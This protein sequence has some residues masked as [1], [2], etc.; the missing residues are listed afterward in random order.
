M[1]RRGAVGDGWL[2][3][4]FSSI[5]LLLALLLDESLLEPAL[6]DARA[7]AAAAARRARL[8]SAERARVRKLGIRELWRPGRAAVV[9]VGGLQLWCDIA[10]VLSE[11]HVLPHL[12][13]HAT[14]LQMQ[15]DAPVGG[16]SG[17]SQLGSIFN[18]SIAANG[19][20]A[21]KG[22][23]GGGWGGFAPDVFV[24][25]QYGDR[26]ATT[27]I[28]EQIHATR[29]S[30]SVF[31]ATEP[32]RSEIE[33]ADMMVGAV[34]VSIGSRREYEQ[35]GDELGG[36]LSV[37]VCMPFL[38]LFAVDRDAYTPAPSLYDNSPAAASG[39]S[40]AV[41]M[42]A[43]A[44][45]TPPPLLCPL[46]RELFMPTDPEAWRARSNYTAFIAFGLPYPRWNVINAMNGLFP[47]LR[48]DAP[49]AGARTMPW[50][51]AF[52]NNASGK[53]AFLKSYRYSICP[54]NSLASGYVTEKLVQAHLAGAVPIYWGAGAQPDVGFPEIF[55]PKRII[56]WEGTSK[57][58]AASNGNATLALRE[59]IMQL[60]LNASARAAFFAEPILAPTAQAWVEKSCSRAMRL[61][62]R[63]FRILLRQ[64]AVQA[65]E[66]ALDEAASRAL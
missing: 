25:G 26:G 20:I 66:A 3:R 48:V 36:G 41:S 2:L 43:N 32:P 29:A 59:R 57:E 17:G 16:I 18:R 13:S 31:F 47:G 46:R 21:A 62:Q 60:E 34:N 58:D 23:W 55:N 52:S 40:S 61:L 53:V 7:A 28:L 63:A 45:A 65:Y 4:V 22:G 39:T 33:Y 9:R 14:G 15:A 24:V 44:V 10:G 30:I 51:A 5:A 27:R 12:F 8:V 19:T 64:Q 54:E 42:R 35:P 49:G 56:M 37:F 38:V 6:A 1:R 50:P 11:I